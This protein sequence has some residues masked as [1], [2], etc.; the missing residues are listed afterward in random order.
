M[1]VRQYSETV[2]RFTTQ[3]PLGM[4]GGLNYYCYVNN[5]PLI[6]IDL[7]G[8]AGTLIIISQLPS[9]R[10]LDYG[11]SWLELDS[12]MSGNI[13]YGLYPF[14]GVVGIDLGDRTGNY[15]MARKHIS[16]QDEC[17]LNQFIGEVSLLGPAAWT[18]VYSCATFAADGWGIATGEFLA[19]YTPAS[20][21]DS[22]KQSMYHVN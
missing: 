17:K 2:G 5:N 21:Y 7:T 22:I 15:A 8:L 20:L 9:D 18:G 14:A 10:T 4:K 1:G 6:S 11:H 16:D 3:D 19:G 13:A 12:D